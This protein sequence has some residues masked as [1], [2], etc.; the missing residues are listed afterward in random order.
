[1]LGETHEVEKDIET[2]PGIQML[3]LNLDVLGGDSEKKD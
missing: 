1:M 2:A 3:Y